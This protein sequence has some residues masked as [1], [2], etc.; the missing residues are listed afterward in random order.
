VLAN[1]LVSQ[2]LK[3]MV[4]NNKNLKAFAAGEKNIGY[5]LFYGRVKPKYPFGTHHTKMMIF[6]YEVKFE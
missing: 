1:T 4:S 5:L 6:V 2:E 3:S